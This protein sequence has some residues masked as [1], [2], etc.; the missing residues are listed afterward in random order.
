M[1]AKEHFE[2]IIV[3]VRISCERWPCHDATTRW[4]YIYLMLDCA[5]EFKG[6]FIELKLQD[7]NFKYKPS[8]Q[9]WKMAK[10]VC[11]FLEVFYDSNTV[12]SK[13]N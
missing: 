11:R 8:D 3:Q 6:I 13:T 7:I 1:S 2:D 12:V 4:N 9:E 10:D 5:S